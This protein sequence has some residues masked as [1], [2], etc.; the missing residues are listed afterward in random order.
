MDHGGD[1]RGAAPEAGVGGTLERE[2]HLSV[3]E[4]RAVPLCCVGGVEPRQ[5]AGGVLAMHAELAA[6]AARHGQLALRA[7]RPGGRVRGALPTPH[8]ARFGA[9]TGPDLAFPDEAW[10]MGWGRGAR[11]HLPEGW[12]AGQRW[13]S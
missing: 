1:E 12:W 8:P 4:A 11:G 6:L 13:T 2:C 10:Q 9:R 5:D 7:D 3:I